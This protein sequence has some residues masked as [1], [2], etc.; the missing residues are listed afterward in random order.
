MQELLQIALMVESMFDKRNADT[1]ECE[2]AHALNFFD[3]AER[4]H[5]PDHA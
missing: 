2:L 3:L 4:N 5:D 1:K